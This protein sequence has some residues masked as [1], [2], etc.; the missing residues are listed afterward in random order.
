MRLGAL[1]IAA[2]LLTASPPAHADP[3]LSGRRIVVDPG[4]G[5]INF[6]KDVINTGKNR[7]GMSEHKIAMEIGLYLGKMLEDDGATVF[8]TRDREDYWREGY[9]P[10]EDNKSRALFA[11]ELKA[12]AFICI[13]CDWHPSRRYQGVTTFYLKDES[14]RLGEAIQRQ[15]VKDLGAFNRKL[16]RD[17]FTVLDHATV[18]TVLVET[19]FLSHR[20]EGK[21][22]LRPDYQKRVAAALASALRGYFAAR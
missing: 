5:T 9:S 4:H 18:P 13:H 14:R 11:N 3:S 19:G 21:K 20:T 6:E 7:D 15:L 17:S 2:V 12:D 16:V 22:L 8:F 10:G 1:G